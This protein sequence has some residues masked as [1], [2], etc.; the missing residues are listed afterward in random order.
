MSDEQILS[1]TAAQANSAFGGL[2]NIL[3]ERSKTTQD[4]ARLIMLAPDFLEARGRFAGEALAK[5]GKNF[6]N[7]QRTALLLGAVTLYTVARVLNKAVDDQFHFEPENLFSMVYKGQ[8]YSLRTVQGDVLHLLSKPMSFWMHRLNP[9][10]ARTGLEAITGR[11]EFGRQR[12]A[13]QQVGDAMSTVIPISIRSSRERSMMESL[14]AAFGVTDRRWQDTDDA[15]RLA[16]KWKDKHGIGE[17][18]EFIYDP[19]KDPL[20][21]LKV[22]L[23]HQDDAGAA[24]EIHRLLQSKAYTLQKLDT[25]FQRYAHMPFTGSNVNDRKWQ[26]DLTDDEKKTVEAAKQH[27]R[28]ILKLYQKSKGQYLAAR[29]GM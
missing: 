29:S 27:K 14:M 19:D 2:N 17:R 25:Y 22:A 10:F 5:G 15:F 20:R 13:A 9:V 21:G 4:M 11:D 8:A 18:G 23:S 16:K 26:Q 28:A 12:S 3:L 1:K 6:G 7:E 24:G